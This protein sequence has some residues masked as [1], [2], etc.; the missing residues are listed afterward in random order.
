MSKALRPGSGSHGQTLRPFRRPSTTPASR[1]AL[2]AMRRT[3]IHTHFAIALSL[4]FYVAI[5]FERQLITSP[6]QLRTGLGVCITA[7][8]DGSDCSSSYYSNLGSFRRHALLNDV[9]SRSRPIQ[10]SLFVRHNPC[11]NPGFGKFS[12]PCVKRVP[13]GE[14]QL[15]YYIE[16]NL[17]TADNPKPGA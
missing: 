8:L 4:Y 9:G 5:T 2:A 17:A 6:A 7:D 11:A 15:C 14:N 10:K 3:P 1:P 16:I 13:I 12:H